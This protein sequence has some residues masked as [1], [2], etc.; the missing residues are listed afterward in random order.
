MQTDKSFLLKICILLGAILVVLAVIAGI[1]AKRPTTDNP[2][3]ESSGTTESTET[4]ESSTTESTEGTG[5]TETTED[6]TETTEETTEQTYTQDFDIEDN[7]FLDALKASGRRPDVGI[8]S[9][10]GK[11]RQGLALSHYLRRQQ[12][13]FGN[14]RRGSS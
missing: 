7:I 12:H 11:E 2:N 8:C 10:C 3:T 14:N 5:T 4:T 9:G 6:T 13:R 1:L